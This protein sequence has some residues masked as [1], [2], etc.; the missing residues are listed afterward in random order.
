MSEEKKPFEWKKLIDFNFKRDW[1]TILFVLWI[2]YMAWAYKYET[3][4]CREIMSNPKPYC[5]NYCDEREFNKFT[6]IEMTTLPKEVIKNWE[7]NVTGT[8]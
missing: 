5:N 7:G 6:T 3:A 8:S 4:E 1:K 2:V